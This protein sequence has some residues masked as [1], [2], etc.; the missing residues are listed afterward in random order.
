[1]RRLALASL[2]AGPLAI[3]A[4]YASA[5]AVGGAPTWGV[6]AMIVGSTL[7]MCGMLALG[8]LRSGMAAGRVAVVTLVLLLVMLAGFGLPLVLP[9]ER[10][11]DALVFGLPLR[12]AIEIYGVGLLPAF[13]LPALFAVEFRDEGLDQAALERLREECRRLRA[14]PR[15]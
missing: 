11:G 14:T 12:A 10:A 6:W 4:A 2:V 7:V 5:W 15:R 9:V 8:A 1:M 13:F 3:G